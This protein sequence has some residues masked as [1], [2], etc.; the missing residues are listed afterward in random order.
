MGLLFPAVVDHSYGRPGPR[1]VKDAGY[2][3]AL[4]YLGD[5]TDGRTIQSAELWSYIN[6]G[7]SVG[8][9]LEGKAD[10]VLGGAGVGAT[11]G[12]RIDWYMNALGVPTSVPVLGVAVDINATGNQLRG[13]IADYARAMISHSTHPILP[14]GD[15]DV[16]EILCGELNLFPCGWQCAA[17]SG[18]GQGSGGSYLCNDGTRRRL[19][20][21]ACM[22]QDVA[23]VLNNTCDHNGILM[24]EVVDRVLWNPSKQTPVNTPTQ[25]EDEVKSKLVYV[26]TRTT[27]RLAKRLVEHGI[28]EEGG[29][30]NV[31]MQTFDDWTMRRVYGPEIAKLKFYGV[32]EQ[33]DQN[34]NIFWINGNEA[35][36]V[37][38][39]ANF[40]DLL[41]IR[42]RD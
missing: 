29:F 15:Y 7:L 23:Y 26:D 13:P 1:A 17:W 32:Q 12:Q 20:K 9:I 27:P 30:E 11:D 34:G 5:P 36:G 37:D 18:L 25:E 38:A 8:F 6:E 22:Y 16:M 33:K 4:R 24:H 35:E 39:D 19:S 41:D 42:D 10:R 28:G 14:Y 31:C 21:Y 2:L 3:G 40:W